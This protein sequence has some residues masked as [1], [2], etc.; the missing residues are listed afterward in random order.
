V[1]DGIFNRFGFER[2]FFWWWDLGGRMHE[3]IIDAMQFGMQNCYQ[4]YDG[5]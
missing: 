1:F 3:I 4:F 2:F 5:S